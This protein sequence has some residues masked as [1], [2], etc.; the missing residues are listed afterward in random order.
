MDLPTDARLKV[1]GKQGQPVYGVDMKITSEDGA[2]L[3]HD[4][5]SFGELKVR[6]LWVCSGY[7][8]M[9]ESDAHDADGWFNTNDVATIDSEGYMQIVDRKKD[10][11]KSGGEWISSIDLED[12]A[13]RHPDVAQAAV[14]GV[15][16]PKWDERP[17][18]LVTAAPGATPD[19]DDILAFFKG[20]IANWWTPDEVL[21]VDSLPIGGTGK[22]QKGELREQYSDY[23]LP[24]A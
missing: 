6:G 3:P 2:A 8:G 9:D 16:H 17:L 14:I 11:I 12:L 15:P 4:G 13:L 7:F 22:I 24:S 19:K 10:V 18:L 5:E 21:V 20:K 1:Q 23:K